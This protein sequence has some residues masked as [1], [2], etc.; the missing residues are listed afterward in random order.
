MKGCYNLVYPFIPTR[1]G[2]KIEFVSTER[3][4]EEVNIDQLPTELGGKY[5]SYEHAF[6]GIPI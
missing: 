1:T 4:Q 2:E 6:D 3:L 5:Y